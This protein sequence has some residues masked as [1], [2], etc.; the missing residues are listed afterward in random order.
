VQRVI[1]WAICF[2]LNGLTISFTLFCFE[3]VVNMNETFYT[4]IPGEIYL[5]DESLIRQNCQFRWTTVI[6]LG[7]MPGNRN[8]WHC[9][10]RAKEGET[11]GQSI[12]EET[13]CSTDDTLHTSTIFRRRLWICWCDTSVMSKSNNC[14]SSK[15]AILSYQ[16][17]IG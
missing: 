2:L 1:C 8:L 11:N 7:H 5:T 3:S 12:E 4:I 13:D 16:R 6:W 15:L 17:F 14:C 9:Y 10:T